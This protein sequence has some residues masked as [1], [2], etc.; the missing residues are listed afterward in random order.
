MRGVPEL[1][2]VLLIYFGTVGLM[3]TLGEALNM[4]GLELSAFAA[5]V[6]SIVPLIPDFAPLCDSVF[7]S[8]LKSPSVDLYGPFRSHCTR[9]RWR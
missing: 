3:N 5:G 4:P 6:N 9:G 7:R 8:S 1:L 2:W